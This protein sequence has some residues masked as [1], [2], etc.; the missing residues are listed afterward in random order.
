MCWTP[1]KKFPGTPLLDSFIQRQ[2]WCTNLICNHQFVPRNYKVYCA[3][4]SI[5]NQTWP[6]SII[7]RA[8]CTLQSVHCTSSHAELNETAECRGLVSSSFASYS[9]CHRFKPQPREWL[10]RYPS[11]FHAN[12]EMA[13]RIRPRRL[14]S[15][16]SCS[17]IAL[18]FDA[19]K[20]NLVNAV[21]SNKKA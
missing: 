18:S 12:A 15:T 16:I 4:I 2:D 19:V 11:S 6:H 3:S 17:V 14:L 21:N 20:S 1:P 5:S 7:D 13:S 10:P 8:F 9:R